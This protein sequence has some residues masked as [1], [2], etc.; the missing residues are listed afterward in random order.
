MAKISYRIKGEGKILICLHGYAG[1]VLHWD[2]VA[3]SLAKQFQVVIPN[4]TH[5]Y[6]GQEQFGFSRQID[7]LANFI[8]ENFPN[9]KISL[10]GISYGGALSWGLALKYPELIDKVVFVNPMPPN[11]AKYFAMASLNVFFRIPLS[12]K[13][14]YLFLSLPVGKY[15]LKE[16]A[17]V[18]RNLQGDFEEHRIESMRGRKLQFMSHV[19]WK[20]S[21]ILRKEKWDMWEQ[22]LQAWSHDCL[23]IYDKK[24]PLF[25]FHF[26][27][28]F[29]K[30]ISSTNVVTTQGAGH[31]SVK[32]ESKL[33]AGA[34]REYLLRDYYQD[35]EGYNG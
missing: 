15:F 22:K 5:L 12:V 33:I 13:M 7:E 20:F 10:A 21:W 16:A 4:L 14:V 19:L 17:G 34:I 31:I 9:Q 26:Y 29:S 24:D 6:A 3:E 11:P 23:L 32:Q 35:A 18:F 25:H 8:Q 27:D 2:A 30:I 1:S 28:Q